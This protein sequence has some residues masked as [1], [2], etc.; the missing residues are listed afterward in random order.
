MVFDILLCRGYK[1]IESMLFSKQYIMLIF[2]IVGV[3]GVGFSSEVKQVAD[4]RK[5]L[6]TPSSVKIQL[7]YDPYQFLSAGY[8]HPPTL[9]FDLSIINAPFYF[10]KYL[11]QVK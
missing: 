1:W 5:N 6:H 11:P 7:K 3:Y 4:S 10:D 8:P 9:V 2:A